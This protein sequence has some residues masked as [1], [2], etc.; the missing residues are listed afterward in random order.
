MSAAIQVD[1]GFE[2]VLENLDADDP[3][4]Q[5]KSSCSKI[6]IEQRVAM[7][8]AKFYYAGGS[9]S[10]MFQ[11]NTQQVCDLLERA[12][13]SMDRSF[14]STE[15]LRSMFPWPG[16]SE[17]TIISVVSRYAALVRSKQYSKV[18]VVTW[19]QFGSSAEWLDAGDGI[20][21]EPP[22]R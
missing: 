5:P 3:L 14:S 20:L 21:L 4:L 1:E 17:L 22:G 8:N 16:S 15:Y 11:L 12:I 2:N 18:K 7:I 10:N 6:S 13:P 9:C 19:T